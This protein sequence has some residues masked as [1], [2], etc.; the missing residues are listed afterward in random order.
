MINE[1]IFFNQFNNEW[2]KFQDPVEIYQTHSLNEVRTILES[3]D[4]KIRDN[5]YVAGFIS[6][7]AAPAF[8]PALKTKN[9]TTF[10]LCWFGL[11]N[12]M[13]I[14]NL[15]DLKRK[16][17][18]V[19]KWISSVNRDDYYRNIQKIKD[20]IADGYTYQVNYTYR[21]STKFSGDPLSYFVDLVGKQNTNYAAFVDIGEFTIC[22]VSP[23]VFF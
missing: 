23:E 13:S 4:D 22:S 18:E 6:Y 5:I 16:K 2:V 17:Y 8:D 9:I 1:A 10:P 12:R 21:L 19:G 15:S 7:E 14:I 3:I 11:Y 20:Y